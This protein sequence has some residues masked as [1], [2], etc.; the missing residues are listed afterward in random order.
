MHHDTHTPNH[1][2]N[3]ATYTTRT[4]I[5][6]RDAHRRSMGLS[7]SL[8][9]GGGGAAAGAAAAA[10]LSSSAANHNSNHNNHHGNNHQPQL[11]N[12]NLRLYATTNYPHHQH[13]HRL[14]TTNASYSSYHH[15]TPPLSYARM[16]ILHEQDPLL[17]QQ[18]YEHDYIEQQLP[19]I[20]HDY[21]PEPHQ[22]AQHTPQH[23]QPQ[24]PHGHYEALDYDPHHDDREHHSA[25]APPSHPIYRPMPRYPP[26][27]SAGNHSMYVPGVVVVV[28]RRC[29]RTLFLDHAA[30]WG[31][32]IRSM[33]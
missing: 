33:Q 16:P 1:Q 6:H 26:F 2:H 25:A 21:F 27:P 8:P 7:P 18:A 31:A 30:C 32:T 23:Y 15:H 11:Q 29:S 22:H 5:H 10:A 19:A 20:A 17:L 4:R 12:M 24:P 14:N 13:Q 3:N 28:V 9:G